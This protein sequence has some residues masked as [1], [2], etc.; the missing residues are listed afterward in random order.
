MLTNM[1]LDNENF[2][3]LVEEAKN[4]IASDY[5]AWTDFNYHDPGITFSELFAY[6]KEIAQYRINFIG[7]R[8]LHK[9]LKLLGIRREPTRPARV[10]V[11]LNCEQTCILPPLTRFFASGVCF[12]NVTA[13]LLTANDISGCICLSGSNFLQFDRRMLK[14]TKTQRIPVFGKNAEPGSIFYMIFDEPLPALCP[15]SLYAGVR[16]DRS[17]PRNPIGGQDSFFALSKV[18]WEYYSDQGWMACEYLSDKTFGFLQSGGI[19]FEIKHPMSRFRVKQTDGYFLKARLISS[20]YD[21]AP[22]LYS[23]SMNMAE[24]VQVCHYAMYQDTVCRRGEHGQIC[25]I[26]VNRLNEQNMAVL[27]PG[28]GFYH[29]HESFS[30]ERRERFWDV[31]LKAEQDEPFSEQV[32]ILSWDKSFDTLQIAGT[33]NGLPSQEFSLGDM[34][35]Y[36]GAF[37]LMVEEPGTDGALCP[38]E[39]VDDFDCSGPGA[40]ITAWI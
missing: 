40:A 29:I 23:I 2:E 22:E 21:V 37:E 6:F 31:T 13:H 25:T 17:V 4:R 15:L 26:E 5:P 14:M 24:A 32:R 12:E 1:D 7:Q 39:S 19:S 35:I 8:H 9:Y 16:N 38:W 36:S 11:S 28:D 34:D 30:I 27:V 10:Q 20:E 18:A 3:D 33:G